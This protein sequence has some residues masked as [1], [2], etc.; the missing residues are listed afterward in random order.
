MYHREIPVFLDAE[1]RNLHLN[2]P[3]EGPDLKIGGGVP[4]LLMPKS[5]VREFAPHFVAW[6][7]KI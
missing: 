5:R 7:F 4:D 2:L 6:I 1:N 3:I